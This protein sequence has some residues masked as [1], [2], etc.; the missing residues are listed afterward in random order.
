MQDNYAV[1][2]IIHTDTFISLVDIYHIKIDKF[3]V[4][5]I[6]SHI[7]KYKLY[8]NKINLHVHIDKSHVNILIF[9]FACLV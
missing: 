3:H 5:M 7:V 4:N 9:H 8:I 2:R 6:I 1:M